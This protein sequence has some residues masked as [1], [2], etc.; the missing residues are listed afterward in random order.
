MTD[1]GFL[2]EVSGRKIAANPDALEAVRGD[3]Q[4]NLLTFKV[5]RMFDGVDLSTK[6]AAIRYQ[7]A[8]GTTSRSYGL[9]KQADETHV[10]FGWLL[11]S[12]V[13][14]QDGTVK[15][16]LEFSDGDGYVW[17]TTL[18]SLTVAPGLVD[19]VQ[20]ENPE[21]PNWIQEVFAEI[22]AKV[23]GA[24]DAA[25]RAEAAA[26]HQPYPNQETG[27]WWVWDVDRG[28]YKDTGQSYNNSG[29]P[30]VASFNGRTGMVVPQPGD[31]T[32]NMVGALPDTAIS[33]PTPTQADAG[34]VPVVNDTVDGYELAVMGGKTEREW[35]KL[36]TIDCSVASGNIEFTDMDFTEFYVQGSL[37]KNASDTAS[38]YKLFINDKQLGSDFL[39]ISNQSSSGVYQYAIARFNGLFWEIRRGSGAKSNTLYQI[40][41]NNA[42]YTYNNVMNVGKAT[43]F[44]L[45]SPALQ[46]V[47][48]SGT[49]EIWS[50]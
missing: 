35:T 26:I 44:K 47:A 7:N 46:Y 19:E 43:K 8:A 12:N 9:N 36:G 28:E 40:S 23:V 4:S 24:V 11:S 3:A 29:T 37:V 25:D 31:Y 16:Q 17:Q 49:I 32:A 2:Y 42:G 15:Y 18:S 41:N 21:N 1:S 50:R 10:T 14:A 6:T 38:A 20:P 30:P 5:P 22:D 39:Q 27:T 45:D 48:V 13:A 33:L 34:K